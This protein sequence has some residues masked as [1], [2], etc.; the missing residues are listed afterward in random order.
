[1]AQDQPKG[2]GGGNK[3]KP[4]GNTPKPVSG[5]SAK[6]KSR[7]Q[8]RPVSGKAPAGKPRGGNSPR[9]AAGAKGGNAPRPG[10]PGA[11]TAK[12]PRGVSGALVAWGAVGLVV[13]IIA[14]LVIVKVTSGSPTTTNASY[15]PVTPAPASIVTDLTNVRAS[16]FDTVGVNIPSQATPNPPTVLSGQPALTIAGKSPA[17]LYYGAEWCP[18]CAA[19][20]WGLA[21]ALARFGTWSGLEVTASSH[22][23]VY[24]ATPTLS[25]A[26]AT[27]TS[28]YLTFFPIETCTN[29]PDA[30]DTSCNG[31]KSLT[32]PTKEEEAVLTKYSSPTYLPGDTTP[33][34]I[35]F[36]FIDIG[37]KALIS[38][39]TYNPQMLA[40]LT[41]ADIASNLDDPTNSVTQTIVGTA[42]YISAAI[43]ASTSQQP[44]KVCDSQG[45]QAATKALKLS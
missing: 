28:P 16:V 26:N 31:Y 45:V 40:G 24:P 7:A 22:T 25:F 3:P 39:A 43:C 14:V 29:I 4:G 6:D 42:N 8:S 27:F 30:S 10:R 9:P 37:N 19:E 2:T 17:M 18:Y 35:G 34:S 38:G 12:P 13:V 23:D 32:Q 20:R 36:P 1:M 33:G 21:V 15:T 44:S 5:Q 41:H 11:S